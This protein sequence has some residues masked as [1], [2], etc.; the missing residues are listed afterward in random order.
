MSSCD[1]KAGG[2]TPS[3]SLSGSELRM[4]L[5]GGSSALTKSAPA[6][7]WA[8]GNRSRHQAQEPT[9]SPTTCRL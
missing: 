2:D 9:E 3:A 7:R 5:I 1:T 6:S 8:L 4:Q